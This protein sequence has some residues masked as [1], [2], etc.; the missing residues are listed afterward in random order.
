MNNRLLISVIL[1]AHV[2]RKLPSLK[3]LRVFESVARNQSFR[4]A[5]DE[6]FVSHSAISHQI[7]MLEEELEAILFNRTGRSISLTPDG[8]YLYPVIR[9][10]FDNME[11]AITHLRA[12]HQPKTLTIQT[13]VTFGTNWLIPKLNDFQKKYP[14]IR[15]RNTISFVDVDFDKDN[16]DIGIIM[17]EKS[18][19]HWHYD[20]LFNLDIFPVCSPRLLESG[21]L[22]TAKDLENFPLIN[23]E[24]AMDD[25][26][27][28]LNAAGVDESI[29][30]Q[31]PIV[32]NYLQALERVYDG[33]ALVMARA[34]FAARDLKEGRLVRPFD[35]VVAEPGTWYMV[36][37]K[38]SKSCKEIALFKQWLVEQVNLDN[39]VNLHS[40]VNLDNKVNPVNNR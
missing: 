7:K 39:S 19:S 28:W 31:G 12:S 32:D 11:T 34:P 36:Y 6:L 8:L 14:D 16:A 38:E 30:D 10:S 20:Y 13:Y 1:G 26:K 22:N 33:E 37:P 24:L 15:V 27:L 18:W 21:K 35:S 3:S 5:A 25:W 17:G 9:D 40:S 23:I 2:I 4:R 29:A